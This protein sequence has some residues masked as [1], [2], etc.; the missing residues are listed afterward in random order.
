MEKVQKKN[1]V[2]VCYKPSSKLNS[3]AI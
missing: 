2:S 3:V 1:T